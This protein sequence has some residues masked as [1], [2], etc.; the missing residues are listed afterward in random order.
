MPS[1][2]Q[3]NAFQRRDKLIFHIQVIMNMGICY[4]N[5]NDYERA[6]EYLDKSLALRK[7]VVSIPNPGFHSNYEYL[8]NFFFKQKEWNNALISYDSALRNGLVAYEGDITS[9]PEEEET[10]SYQDLSTLTKKAASLKESALVTE[11]PSDL[12]ISSKEYVQRIHTLLMA[13][14]NEFIATEGKLFLSQNF[15]SLYE[16]GIDACFELY[17]STGDERYF[18]DA[19]SFAKDSKAI[20]FLEQSHEFNLVNNDLLAQEVKERFFSSKRKVEG[21][22]KN[23]YQLINESLIS[24]SVMVINNLLS[25]A[26]S[27]NQSLKDSIDLIL[28]DFEDNESL[29]QNL[30]DVNEEIKLKKGEVLIEFFYGEN[31][32]YVLSKSANA[33]S[34]HRILIDEAIEESIR[35][36]IEISSIAPKAED[37]DEDF[38][39]FSKHSNL[40]YQYLIEP[41]IDDLGND[42]THLIIVPDEFLSRLPFEVFVKDISGAGGFNDLDY[43]IKSYSIQY[44][45]SSELL[46]IK[47]NKRKSEYAMLGIGFQQSEAAS[48]RSNYGSLPGTEREIRFLQSSFK[49]TYLMGDTGSKSDFLTNA[50]DYDILHLAIHGEADSLSLY[51]SSL[52]F[53]GPTN[54]N[55]LRTDDLYLAGLQARLAVLSSCESGVGLINKGEG[56]FSIARGFALVGVPSIVM[57]LWKVNDRIT[58]GLM[59]D[60]Y[61]GFLEEGLP[62]NEALRNSKLSY[63]E[64]SDSYASHPYYWAAFLQLGQ[65][66]QLN[67]GAGISLLTIMLVVLPLIL[68]TLWLIYRKRKRAI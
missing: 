53:N 36:V 61:R 34:F 17:K 62:I 2:D 9:F 23:F 28:A 37:M 66:T 3:G 58:S 35:K 7:E 5:L 48:T 31:N 39:E 59:V 33:I 15:K 46:N 16:T 63:L 19:M 1:L 11:E 65:N 54:E 52:I 18:K 49:G 32:I 12:L 60:M 13:S 47:S 67:E 43:L 10:F 21:L 14:R 57:S 27:E 20:L 68:L 40:L 22:Q 30:L 64:R 56:T 44:E 26:R 29:F 50:R 24:D 51:E 6:K 4:E 8:G 38:V 55:I 42:L 45:L 41:A 25:D